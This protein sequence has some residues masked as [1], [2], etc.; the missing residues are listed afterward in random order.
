REHLP[1]DNNHP[2]RHYQPKPPLTPEDVE[3]LK[4][5][6][7]RPHFPDWHP[8]TPYMITTKPIRTW[9]RSYFVQQR[10]MS[11]AR[12]M[13][14]WKNLTDDAVMWTCEWVETPRIQPCILGVR[15]LNGTWTE[16]IF[17]PSLQGTIVY[18]PVLSLRQLGYQLIDIPDSRDSAYPCESIVR[19]NRA[20]SKI[21]PE[22]NRLVRNFDL[23]CLIRSTLTTSKTSPGHD[24]GDGS[25]RK[26]QTIKTLKRRDD[27]DLDDL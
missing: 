6:V 12:L 26:K 11:G 15:R 27:R 25:K 5:L 9:I 20:A 3:E 13:R 8:A 18:Q 10:I 21:P 16:K 14:L 1:A 23:P 24:P 2:M 22:W 17:I 19:T 7:E 4:E